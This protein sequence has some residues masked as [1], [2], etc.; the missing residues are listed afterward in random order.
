MKTKRATKFRVRPFNIKNGNTAPY[1][2]VEPDGRAKKDEVEKL[3]SEQFKQQS[4][5]AKYPNW[6]LSIEKV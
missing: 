1:F 6:D 5:L 3:A 2:L 4:A